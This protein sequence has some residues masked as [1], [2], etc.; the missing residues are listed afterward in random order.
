VPGREIAR[1]VGRGRAG[2]LWLAKRL[3]VTRAEVEAGDRASVRGDGSTRADTDTPA[4]DAAGNRSEIERRALVRRQPG[5]GRRWPPASRR[6][7]KFPISSIG[8]PLAARNRSMTKG[9]ETCRNANEASSYG[10]VVR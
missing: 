6:L 10:G 7:H 1:I 8:R 9:P 5:G 4:G 2:G 3:R